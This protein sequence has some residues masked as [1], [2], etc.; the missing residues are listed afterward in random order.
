MIT[1]STLAYRVAILRPVTVRDIYGAQSVRYAYV[2]DVWADVKFKK[3]NRALDHGEVW[4]P[5]TIV[6]TTRLHSD[7]NERVR[8]RW[9]GKVYQIDSLNRDRINGSLTI[10][11]TEVDKGSGTLDGGD[12]NNDFNNDFTSDYPMAM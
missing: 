5:T 9:D 3:G 4:L 11:A 2:R 7:I 8:L 1:A 6:I 12:F 10:T